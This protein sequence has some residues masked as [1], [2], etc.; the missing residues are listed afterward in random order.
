MYCH[1]P[2][3]W[4]LQQITQGSRQQQDTGPGILW[5]VHGWTKPNTYGAASNLQSFTNAP[6]DLTYYTNSSNYLKKFKK[7]ERTVH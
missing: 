3:G 5:S 6:Q 1:V 4:G 7:E 2:A